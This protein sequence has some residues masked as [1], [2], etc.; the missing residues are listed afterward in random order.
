MQSQEG[1]VASLN[2]PGNNVT[3]VNFFTGVLGA[4]RLEL[5]RQLVPKATTIGVLVN[6]NT[7]PNGGRAKGRAGSS[8]SDR[9]ATHNSRCQQRPRHRDRPRN[10][11]PTWGW[12]TARRFRRIHEL[13]SGTA[14]RAGGSP[15]AGVNLCPAGVKQT[16]SGRG[17]ADGPG[18][19]TGCCAVRTA[20]RLWPATELSGRRHRLISCCEV[21]MGALSQFPITGAHRPQSSL[22]LNST[23]SLPGFLGVAESE[24]PRRGR[25][26]ARRGFCYSIHEMTG[27]A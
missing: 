22:E 6:P 16:S 1:L 4:K 13:P 12:R 17:V 26:Y 25:M 7:I 5:L 24:E 23:L 9:A 15:C 14:D 2:R 27:F 11:R 10:A 20:Q 3:G 18:K 19:S 8:G 21:K